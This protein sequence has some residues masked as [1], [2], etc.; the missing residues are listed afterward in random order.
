MRKVNRVNLIIA[1]PG[2][3]IAFLF[4]VPMISY[5]IPAGVYSCPPNGCHFLLIGSITYWAFGVGGTWRESSA[6][7][8]E[9]AIATTIGRTTSIVSYAVT[10]G[11]THTMT[12]ISSSRNGLVLRLSLNASSSSSSG[13]SLT[14]AADDFNGLPSANNVTAVN[15]WS[16]SLTGLNGPPCW[17]PGYPVGLAIAEG[18]YSVSN[19]SSAKFVDL[20]NPTATY[21]CGPGLSRIDAY[22]F[23]PLSDIAAIYG[24]CSPNPCMTEKISS[25]VTANGY[26]NQDGTFTDFPRGAYTIVAADEWGLLAAA[27]FTVT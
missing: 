14:A 17:F 11:P 8:V 16:L 7:S 26:W 23:R 21:A 15:N 18:Y 1:V 2:F 19:I 4:F 12:A 24:S 10:V 5:S 22:F 6:Y 9:I 20:V 27:Y 25:Q 13:V 3:V